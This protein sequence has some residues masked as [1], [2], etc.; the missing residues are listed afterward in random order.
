[1]AL[2]KEL[3][4]KIP[5]TTAYLSFEKITQ[6]ISERMDVGILPNGRK[7]VVEKNKRNHIIGIQ[8]E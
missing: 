8:I 4:M 7:L 5:E 6:P 1:M 3:V 2:H